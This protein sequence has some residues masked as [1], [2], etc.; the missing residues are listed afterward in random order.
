MNRL[1][2]CA[3][4]VGASLLAV[5]QAAEANFL[6]NGSLE[7]TV[8][9]GSS[10]GGFPVPAPPGT[11]DFNKR[12]AFED[13][14]ASA[15]NALGG[16]EGFACPAAFGAGCSDK[17]SYVASMQS[18]ATASALPRPV[19]MY[20]TVALQA[21][22][23]RFGGDVAMAMFAAAVGDNE[24]EAFLRIYAGEITFGSGGAPN[25]ASGAL[26]A[27]IDLSPAQFDT[28][29]FSI[30]LGGTGALRGRQFETF[31]EVFTLDSDSL[32]T[33][34]LVI[35]PKRV[36][37]VTAPPYIDT[38]EA[39]RIEASSLTLWADNLFIEA[40]RIQPVPAP[41]A[42]GV[43]AVALAGLALARRRKAG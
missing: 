2:L 31:E 27:S 24:S 25:G 8:T 10:A 32:V 40:T 37:P 36:S 41:G 34:Q 22:E 14:A 17:G 7:A 35:L 18:D 5:P 4:A 43:F 12:I 3:V 33:M 28:G 30:T 29:D 42:L 1:S 39:G 20:Q 21:G 6:L 16:M 23:Y 9:V 38:G 13:W 15:Y 19:A 11:P 26:L